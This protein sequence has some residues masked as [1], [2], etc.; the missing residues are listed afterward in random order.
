MKIIDFSAYGN[1]VRFYY[2]LNSC[3]DY[4]GEDWHRADCDDRV[5]RE[6][7]RGYIDI[8]VDTDHIIL[9][10]F[11]DYPESH[12]C[13]NDLKARRAPCI[14]VMEQPSNGID[15]WNRYSCGDYNKFC[16]SESKGS[17]RIYY[18]DD[19]SVLDQF[20]VLQRR[21]YKCDSKIQH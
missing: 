9:N 6:Y 14:V 19:I 4:H 10:P 2:G 17:V 1:V 12:L 8:A 7:I 5:Y 11:N 15:D 3:N 18:G 20:T 16:G 13:K 21:N